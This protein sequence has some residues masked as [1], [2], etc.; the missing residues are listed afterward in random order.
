MTSRPADDV[1]DTEARAAVVRETYENALRSGDRNVYFVDGRTL[2]GD[3][4]PAICTTDRTHP[5]DLGHYLMAK[6]LAR[7][8]TDRGILTEAD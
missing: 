4:D 7:L 5:N 3:T 8:L 2:F 6:T 1:D